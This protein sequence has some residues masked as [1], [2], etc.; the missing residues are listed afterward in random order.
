MS[1]FLHTG[2]GKEPGSKKGNGVYPAFEYRP[3]QFL[4]WVFLRSDV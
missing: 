1:L 3:W 2:S 4:L